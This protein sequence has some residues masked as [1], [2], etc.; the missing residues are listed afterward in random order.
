MENCRNSRSAKGELM[1]EHPVL[2]DVDG[3]V[4]WLR[5]N[6]PSAMNALNEAL[7]AA[8]ARELD[9][10]RSNTDARV[11]VITG[12]GR[13]FCTGADLKA[14]AMLGEEDPRQLITFVRKAATLFDQ[15]SALDKPVIAAVNGTAAAGGLELALA[16]DLVLAADSAR[17][18]DAH[19][20]FGLLPGGGGAARLT[21]VVGPMVAK[22]LAFT[23]DL[24]PASELVPH[25]LVNEVVPAGDLA[26]RATDVAHSIAQKSPLGLARMKCLIDNTADLPL[27]AALRSE[28]ESLQAHAYST[29]MREGLTAFREKRSPRYVGG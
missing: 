7:I 4:V 15:I 21:R 5:L 9:D 2:R 23:G 1:A 11:V 29:D 18:G 16:C 14:I 26:K 27:A 3:P 13:A 6:R 12:E 19:A 22:R 24:I 20:N 8:L 17:M 10:L 28:L 25:G